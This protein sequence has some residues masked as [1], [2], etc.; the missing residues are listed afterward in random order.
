V[1][2]QH[3]GSIFGAALLW[4][5]FD[6]V[7]YSGILFGPLLIAK[8][9]GLGPTTFSLIMS[10]IF[11]IPGALL[12][13]VLIDRIGRKPLQTIGFLGSALMLGLFAWLH[14]VRPAGRDRR[15]HVACPR[16]A[17]WSRLHY[18]ADPGDRAPLARRD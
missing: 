8:G 9:L 4:M 2:A 18:A 17:G 13:V 10:F 5:L 11:V 14:N 15:D 7:I 12:G 3:A 16:V 6:I 1:F